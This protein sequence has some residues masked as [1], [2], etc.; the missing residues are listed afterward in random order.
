MKLRLIEPLRHPSCLLRLASCLLLL[1][2]C[3]LLLAS[4][5]AGRPQDSLRTWDPF[6]DT[7][8]T[9]TLTYFLA[10]MDSSTGLAPDR[11]PSRSPSSVAA[12]G[13]A[14]TS[15][16]I[17]SE[18][19]LITRGEAA[20]RVAKTLE[21]LYSAPQ[22]DR[23]DGATGYRGF[24][25]HFVSIPDGSR[26]WKCELS[27]IDT[28]LLMAGVLF[29]QSFFDRGDAVES[30]IRSLADSLYRRVDWEW[31][32]EDR[33]GLM[34]GW[35]P[36][37]GADR[38]SW[39][40]YNEAMILYVLAFGSP[41]HP[42]PSKGWDY[43]TSSYVWATY[44][45][46]QFVSF[47]PLFGHQFSHC[48]I[49]FRGIQDRYM[50]EKG[51]DYFEN[52]RRA[53]YSQQAYA[54][55]NPR[56]YRGYSDTVWGVTPCD[57]PGDTSFVVDGMTRRFLGYAGRGV[58]FDWALD[59][60]TIAPTGAGASVAFAPEI[61]IPTLKALGK[62]Y[63]GR[64]WTQFGFRDAFNPTYVTQ[65]T[66]PDGW[67]DPDYLGLDQGPIAIMLE[68]LRTGLVWDVMRKNPYVVEG[69]RRA[70]FS[71]GWLEKN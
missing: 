17:A 51:I 42:A 62:T 15:Y 37:G 30:R 58:S 70:G 66:G 35:T 67:F 19:G 20:R 52:S 8:E 47:G 39:H 57:G 18:R 31:A 68:N 5:S 28:A 9:R 61:C 63:A 65:R 64:L 43:W 23:P 36:E 59:D 2:S 16:P 33:P 38:E 53:T 56:H 32:S 13:F 71:G 69:L 25:Y 40:G 24:F 29:C 26:A 60:G 11:W 6:L 1:A 3:V 48:W 49:D 54:I 34:L 44:Y 45:G 46:K 4:C 21:F 27:T 41:T 22:S 50:R 12:V 55:E 14:L 7:L 10:T